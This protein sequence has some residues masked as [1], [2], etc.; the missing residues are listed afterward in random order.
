MKRT[1]IPVSMV[2][3]TLFFQFLSCPAQAACTWNVNFPKGV[4]ATSLV[5]PFTVREYV[6]ANSF[7]TLLATN[8]GNV[9]VDD[10]GP[11][12]VA[13]CDNL[14]GDA[15]FTSDLELSFLGLGFLLGGMPITDV[16]QQTRYGPQDPIGTLQAAAFNPD[17]S[18]P[19]LGNWLG[20]A[21]FTQGSQ[22]GVPD[23]SSGSL[24]NLF[25]GVALERWADQGFL[26]T[27]DSLGS[28]YQIVNGRATL[29]LRG[30]GPT[31]EQLNSFFFGTSEL[32]PGG[33]WTGPGYSGTADLFGWHE[34]SSPIPESSTFLLLSGG[35]FVLCIYRWRT[36]QVTR[37]PS[38]ASRAIS[39][40]SLRC[41]RLMKSTRGGLQST[42]IK[43]GPSPTP[44]YKSNKAC[45]SA[46]LPPKV[47]VRGGL[48]AARPRAAA[49]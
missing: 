49:S 34:F 31:A 26:M 46:D 1:I 24:E 36:W 38:P 13:T 20:G 5:N 37:H 7:V 23:F 43:G 11:L 32:R 48:V 4:E 3:L 40:R 16:Q 9:I 22:L 41:S 15:G 33:S 18:M 14:T 19:P 28:V 47:G 44:Q 12:G 17:G 39:R 8:G 27:T 30:N 29:R 6:P 2:F 45:D 21:G 10:T 42:P 25:F 35:L